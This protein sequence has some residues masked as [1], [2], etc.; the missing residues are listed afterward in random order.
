MFRNPENEE[1]DDF[2]ETLKRRILEDDR[3]VRQI[4]IAAGVDRG[5]IYG[6]L[7]GNQDTLNVYTIFRLLVALKLVVVVQEAEAVAN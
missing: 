3:T 5:T 2:M 6:F 7:R 4:C 1:M